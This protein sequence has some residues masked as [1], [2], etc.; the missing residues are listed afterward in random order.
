MNKPKTDTQA[1]AMDAITGKPMPK[2]IPASTLVIF[3]DQPGQKAPDLLMVERSAKMVFAAG[4]A[5]FPGG[6]IDDADFEFAK[7]LGH[8]DFDEYGARIAAVRESIE[9][10]GIAVAVEGNL[11]PKRVLEA[12]DAL[13]AGTVLA[14][15]CNQFDWQLE[16]EKLIPF[17]RWCPPFAEKRVFDTRFYM[18]SHDDHQAEATVDETENYNLFWSNA[19]SVLDRAEAGEVKIIFPTKRNLERLAQFGSFDEAVAHVK[20]HP[21]VMVS[22]NIENGARKSIC[23]SRKALAIRS[24][25]SRWTPSSAVSRNSRNGVRQRRTSP[26][27]NPFSIA[28][29]LWFT[30]SL[31]KTRRT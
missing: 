20:E 15:I 11:D 27:C 23:A 28:A 14:D 9:E 13:H 6:R 17:S 12:R 1:P 2:P 26:R 19:Q 24:L 7:A 30:F 5:V 10:T 3:R 29:I 16:L 8:T 4:A 31:S 25:R 21:S 22:P 18:I